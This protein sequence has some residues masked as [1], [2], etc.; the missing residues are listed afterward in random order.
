ME[1]A[2]QTYSVNPRTA[3]TGHQ[4]GDRPALARQ[5]ARETGEPPR[6][7]A[8]GSEEILRPIHFSVGPD[9]NRY[10]QGYIQSNY[11]PVRNG[12]HQS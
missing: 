4:P 1:T 12:Q 10:H 11:Y 7:F 9:T 6:Q 8:A 2:H 5:G 3:A